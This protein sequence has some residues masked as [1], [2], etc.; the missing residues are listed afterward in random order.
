MKMVD[1]KICS[2]C[3]SWEGGESFVLV[4]DLMPLTAETVFKFNSFCKV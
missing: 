4:V 3:A 1:V 2:S